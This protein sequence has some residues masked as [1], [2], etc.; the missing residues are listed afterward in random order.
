MELVSGVHQD[1]LTSAL[2]RAARGPRS[3]W[4][5][6]AVVIG[7]GVGAGRSTFLS[8]L[9]RALAARGYRALP[10]APV[11]GDAGLPYAV[12][13]DLL[14]DVAEAPSAGTDP[15]SQR[16]WALAA[17]EHARSLGPVIIAIDDISGL[18]DCS[19]AIITALLRRDAA[20][21]L[22]LA[23]T[24][25]AWPGRDVHSL[26]SALDP[27]EAVHDVR[28]AALS[29]EEAAALLAAVGLDPFEPAAS[30][31]ICATAGGHPLLVTELGRGGA[32]TRANL[33]L[34][35]DQARRVVGRLFGSRTQLQET[36]AA[37]AALGELRPQRIGLLAAVLDRPAAELAADLDT[38]MQAGLVRLTGDRYHGRAALLDAALRATLAPATAWLWHRRAAEWLHCHRGSGT[39]ALAELA[40]HLAV[41]AQP[42]D[43]R[44][45]AILLNAADR[46]CD[47]A[48]RM[49][50][51]WYRAAIG[52]LPGDDDRLS[53][54]Q[55]GLARAACLMGDPVRAVEAGRAALDLLPPGPDHDRVLR[56][57]TDAGVLGEPGLP[58]V[59]WSDSQQVP[60][61]LALAA[62]L[63]A[64]S[65]RLAE[66]AR[67]VELVEGALH[68]QLPGEQ[69]HCL[70]HV[71]H[72]EGL[73]GRPAAMLA[74]VDRVL[75]CAAGS[76]LLR[77][78]AQINCAYLLALHGSDR[79]TALIAGCRQLIEQTGCDFGRTELAL[80]TFVDDYRTGRWSA[81]PTAAAELKPRLADNHA[82]KGLAV[83]QALEADVLA[84]CGHPSAAGKALVGTSDCAASAALHAW[85]SAG[86][87][88]ASGRPQAATARLE[89]ALGPVQV[90]KFT[91]FL[92]VRQAEAQLALGDLQAAARTAARVDS[93]VAGIST[94]AT[95]LEAA[96]L[97]AV[98]EH[99]RAALRE[100]LEHAER[101]RAAPLGARVRFELARLGDDPEAHL[102]AAY[103]TF[104]ALGADPWR[105]Q[106]IHELQRRG[107]KV[108]RH[109][110]A[111]P[112]GLTTAEL[113]VARLVQQ[114]LR[115]RDIATALSMS[116][117]TVESYLTRVYTKTGC[118][119]R[120]GL[121]RALDAHD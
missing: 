9:S 3:P 37:I 17:I 119:S 85:A 68:R 14:A 79:A 110:T 28:L 2:G 90:P 102:R 105:R 21:P 50:A 30:A 81:L 107:L 67:A 83:V 56:L 114:G 69:V 34:P 109:R 32:A 76:L 80:A 87:D 78:S 84:Q 106:V 111:A 5:T 49:A 60:Q 8:C 103:E 31:R 66:A 12:L 113:R 40:D 51:Q 25:P 118:S 57:V 61:L 65:G 46:A 54:G 24:R 16:R 108:P 48:P 23:I 6:S 62:H 86:V 75:G 77:I 59:S 98:A 104:H 120:L 71:A 115:N 45:I 18:D 64:R 35:S 42:G 93:R 95:A 39:D 53:R 116:V 91:E 43:D 33:T 70:T 58:T 26:T 52:L 44:D 88:L 47:S 41:A 121:A 72:A 10:A 99:D 82:D 97:R 100:C 15:T 36:A 74:T 92:L 1:A 29:V 19:A 63:L 73:L 13:D 55:S 112:A 11:P 96:R 101:R 4:Q 27:F 7:G 38:L 94:T 22:L 89:A 117:K 20:F